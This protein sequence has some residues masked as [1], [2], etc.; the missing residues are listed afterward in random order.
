MAYRRDATLRQLA[1]VAPSV[2]E[3]GEAI[4]AAVLVQRGPSPY[5]TAIPLAVVLMIERADPRPGA[6][7]SEVKEGALWNRLTYRR[8]DGQTERFNVGW[9]WRE[10]MRGFVAALAAAP[11][12]PPPPAPLSAP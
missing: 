12:M 7:V 6:S 2:L 9:N 4:Q 8:A 11:P 5:V 1:E 10:Q 3:P